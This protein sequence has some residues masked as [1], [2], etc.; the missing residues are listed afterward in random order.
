VKIVAHRGN[1]AEFRENSLDA[2]RSALEIGCK[3][4]EFDVRLSQDGVPVLVHDHKLKRI[5]NRRGTVSDYSAA[6]LWG[7][8]IGRLSDAM[9]L[10]RNHGAT[11]F[12]DLK[13]DSRAAV[14]A[15][16]PLIG[17]H[18]LLSFNLDLLLYARSKGDVSIG[19]IVTDVGDKVR[20][21]YE[22]ALPD[23][24]FIEQSLVTAPLW[25]AQ[26]VAYGKGNVQKLSEFG[27]R[28][29]ETSSP[30]KFIEGCV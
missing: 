9:A 28:Y 14:D 13:P 29:I 20:R 11:A 4:V 7:F 27:V 23:F 16:L 21:R 30:R 10:V 12:V 5:F 1:A 19:W 8:G 6:Q 26:W 3:Y 22:K 24:L 25:P 17:G 15:V 18:T 2:I